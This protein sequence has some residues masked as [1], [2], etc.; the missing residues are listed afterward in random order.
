MVFVSSTTE[1]ILNLFGGRV[2]ITGDFNSS[3]RLSIINANGICDITYV[4]LDVN[5]PFKDVIDTISITET[6]KYCIHPSDYGIEG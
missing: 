4:V 3:D 6:K 1:S 5:K 2:G